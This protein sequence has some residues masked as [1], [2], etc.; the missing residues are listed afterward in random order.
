MDYTKL[1]FK[2]ID[3]ILLRPLDT[4]TMEISIVMMDAVVHAKLKMVLS[5]IEIP[6]HQFVLK[7]Y[8]MGG[9]MELMSA[10]PCQSKI[11]HVLME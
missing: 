5:A 8:T 4:A 10:T 6:N 9:I 11:M 1:I 3:S 2:T 7:I